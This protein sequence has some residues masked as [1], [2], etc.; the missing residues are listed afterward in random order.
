[1][2][3]SRSPDTGAASEAGVSVRLSPTQQRVMKWLGKGWRT[4]PAAG[5]ALNVNGKRICNL[6]TLNALQRLGLVNRLEPG[7]WEASTLGR[8]VTAEL[9]L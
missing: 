2:S 9:G 3:N 7:V 6:D 8:N 4:E 1:M 5:S